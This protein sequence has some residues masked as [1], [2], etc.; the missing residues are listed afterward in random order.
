MRSRPRLFGSVAVGVVATI[1]LAAPTGWRPV[2]RL[3]VDW[4]SGV[5]LYLGLAFRAAGAPARP[6]GSL[7]LAALTILLSWTLIHTIFALHYAH[8]FYDETTGAGA[9]WRSRV[10]TSSR[11]SGISS[12]F[13]S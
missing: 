8:E 3:L 4:D 9:A 5:A 1:A 13:Q 10:A 11:T 7:V 2:T 6:P 12:T